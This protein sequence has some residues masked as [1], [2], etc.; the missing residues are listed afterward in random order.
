MDPSTKPGLF[1]EFGRGRSV[2]FATCSITATKQLNRRALDTIF[3]PEI[4]AFGTFK[5]SLAPE[6]HLEPHWICEIH[7]IIAGA[8]KD[9]LEKAFAI[10]ASREKYDSYVAVTKVENI[11]QAISEVLRAD[12]KGWQH[13]LWPDGSPAHSA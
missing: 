2:N 12:L 4:V 13:P 10:S 11:G 9:D 5:V 6:Y 7:E 3:I 1:A 8:P